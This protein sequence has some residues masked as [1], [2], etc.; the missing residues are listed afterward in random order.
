MNF[1]YIKKAYERM[2]YVFKAP[3]AG[4]IRGRIID[5]KAFQ[6]QYRELVEHDNMSLTDME[7]RQRS[8][9]KDA[10]IH[11]YEHTRYYHKIFDEIEFD[12][13]S[14]LNC[15]EMKRIPVLTKGELKLNFEDL[16]ADDVSSSYTVTTGGTTGSPTTV[17][18]SNEAFYREWAF[19]YHFWSKFGYD[20]T[21][22]RL[23]TFRGVQMGNK[24]CEINPMYQEIRMNPFL[25][26]KDNIETYW[27]KINEYRADFIY[28][29]PSAIY[30]FCKLANQAD[31]KLKG[32][33][34]AVLL[35]SENLYPFQEE[36]I[37]KSLDCPI[38]IFYGHSERAVF[39]EKLDKGYVF[40]PLYGFTELSENDEPIVTG[41]INKKMPLIRYLV[42]DTVRP[43][44]EDKYD[45]EGHRD[46]SV[47]YGTDGEEISAAAIN[48]H[49]NTFEKI[50]AYQFVQE[51]RGQCKLL[52]KS[53]SRL[54][55]KELEK[56]QHN[57]V[58]KLGTAI[59]CEVEQCEQLTYTNRGKFK[60]IIQNCSW[61]GV[62]LDKQY[63]VIGHHNG[64]VLYG[65]NGEE[66]SAAAINFHDNT[67]EKIEAYQFVQEV[68]GQCKLLVKSESRLTDKELEKIQHSV[69]Q[70]LGTAIQCEVE[71]CEQLTYT[72]R[73]K[74][75]LI[76]QNVLD[77]G[78]IK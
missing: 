5:N 58:Q 13:Y 41:F 63:T 52:V 22:S 49:D 34:K 32:T 33:F 74:F 19:I 55:D 50:E 78:Y 67:F 24:I 14:F 73:G 76:I 21:K 26:N 48:F 61:G 31:I 17:Q 18:M 60:L 65:S 54:T 68:R 30:N 28:G 4:F 6:Q 8:L 38:A 27:K 2:P 9:L 44:E 72:N 23:A 57:V 53:E 20:Y 66:I 29:Y 75:K 40:N 46:S 1:N 77:D 59:Q 36:V 15:V 35:I 42:D 3:F 39:G 64:D 69:V 25:M 62:T 10:L 11:A 71:Q 56:I 47:I 12:P 70:K 37:K 51:V 43:I 45:I 7:N 16:C